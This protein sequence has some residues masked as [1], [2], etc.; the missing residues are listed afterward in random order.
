MPTALS[1]GF[2]HFFFLVFW[3]CKISLLY[4]A[5]SVRFIQECL[6]FSYVCGCRLVRQSLLLFYFLFYE[7]AVF[8]FELSGVYL[9]HTTSIRDTRIPFF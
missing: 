5:I 4:S 6:A 7:R 9:E 1:F 2:A 8:T 3:F